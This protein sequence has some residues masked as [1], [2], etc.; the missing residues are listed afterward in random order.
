MNPTNIFSL[1]NSFVLFGWILLL[2][3]PKWRYTQTVVLHGIVLLLA[4]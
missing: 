3:L 4:V 2:F 1:A